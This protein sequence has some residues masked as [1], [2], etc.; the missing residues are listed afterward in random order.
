MITG[1][2]KK[3]TRRGWLKSATNAGGNRRARI[4]YNVALMS[5][6]VHEIAYKVYQICSGITTSP[7]R[8]DDI[9]HMDVKAKK[10]KGIALCEMSH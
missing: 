10:A 5:R 1:I 3:F 8:F 6:M 4:M 2:K 7:K 9:C